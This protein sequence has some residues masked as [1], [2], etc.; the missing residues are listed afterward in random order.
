MEKK[1]SKFN[2]LLN[3]LLRENPVLVL[4]LGTCPTLAISTSVKGAIG[5]GITA[6]IV[7]I[8]SNFVISLIK[9]IIPDKIRIPAYIVVIAGFVSVMQMLVQAYF[10]DIYELLGVYLPLIV[11]NCIVLGRAE[12]FA[13]KNTVLDSVLDGLGMGVGF[14]LALVI[15]ASI[16]E[17]LGA[18]TWF[19]IQ[20]LPEFIDPVG[21]LISPPGG[22][23]VYGVVIA[24]VAAITRKKPQKQ[25]CAGCGNAAN[26][27]KE[28]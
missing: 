16:R 20:V 27:S 1:Q 24:L 25:G 18:G 11:V 12:A 7:L 28:G 15:M 8:C 22:F 19:G 14:S 17:V 13:S 4:L 21:I 5:M 10:P 26:A 6:T 2:I 3:G 23:F 9:N